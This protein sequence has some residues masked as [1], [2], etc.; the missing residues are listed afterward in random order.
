MIGQK[1]IDQK[2]RQILKGIAAASVASAAP[3]LASAALTQNVGGDTLN[4]LAEDRLEVTS[5]LSVIKND[6]EVVLTN[7]SSRPVTISQVTPGVIDTPRGRFD[8]SAALSNGSV[9]LDAGKN[10]TVP[11]QHHQVVLD[12][13]TATQRQE[14]L[15]NMLKG[16]NVVSDSNVPVRYVA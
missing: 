10:I 2:K 8:I 4:N 13:S 3:T 7:K 15:Q 16:F 6:L 12:S 11:I 9:R 5:R 14:S 1:K